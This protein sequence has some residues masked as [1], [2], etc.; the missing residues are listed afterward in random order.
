MF[1]ASKPCVV[2][3]P[4]EFW[5]DHLEESL[6]DI[7][8]NLNKYHGQIDVNKYISDLSKCLVS[9]GIRGVVSPL[10]AGKLEHALEPHLDKIDS[11]T[12]ESILFFIDGTG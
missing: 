12:A 10:F 11:K 7:L 2:H 9:F 5:L 1:F 6:D 3:V 8:V 4:A